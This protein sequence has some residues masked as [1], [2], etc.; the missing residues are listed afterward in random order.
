MI[1]M[2]RKGRKALVIGGDSELGAATAK[3]LAQDGRI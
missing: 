1:V 3:S 2:E